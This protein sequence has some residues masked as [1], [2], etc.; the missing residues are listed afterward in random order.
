MVHS[1]TILL[2][3]WKESLEELDLAVKIM[4]RDVAT[5]WNSTFNMLKFS[6]EYR[7][8]IEALTSERKNELRQ[9]E[10]SEEEWEIAGE[11]KGTLEVRPLVGP[12]VHVSAFL[13]AVAF[14]A[15][16]FLPQQILKDATLF[17]SRA[18]PNLATV[19]PAMDHIDTHFTN[20]ILPTSTNNPAI[21]AAIGLG[22]RT[23][24]RYYSKT[25]MVEVYRIAMGMYSNMIYFF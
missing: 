10:L 22:K 4:P 18:T 17:F 11:L 9:F 3:V 21:C 6:L 12:C 20:A 24:N 7:K 2:P 1:T 8:A 13:T 15:P 16:T 14:G 23:L 25:D 19:I 5:R